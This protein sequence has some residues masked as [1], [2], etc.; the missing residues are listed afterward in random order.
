ASRPVRSRD[1]SR[2]GSLAEPR[3]Q[4]ST[5]RL[6]L[7]GCAR[8]CRVPEGFDST[9]GSLS[10]Y[11]RFAV[12][13]AWPSASG[14]KTTHIYVVTRLRTI[15]LCSSSAPRVAI[16]LATRGW[17]APRTPSERFRPIPSAKAP[18][19]EEPGHGV[20]LHRYRHGVTGRRA[21]PDFGE[22]EPCARFFGSSQRTVGAAQ[23][24]ASRLKAS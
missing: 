23:T 2:A 16:A 1:S 13:F 14:Y 3:S 15:A 11:G 5:R 21:R 6:W 12:A 24:S 20:T 18:A 17:R 7:G 4:I 9:P 22:S 19:R 10:F 8:R